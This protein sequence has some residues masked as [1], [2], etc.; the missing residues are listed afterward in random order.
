V[1]AYARGWKERVRSWLISAAS[2][3]AIAAALGGIATWADQ[4]AL[5]AAGPGGVPVH[6]DA[7]RRFLT[8]YSL[9]RL[10]GALEVYRLERG[11]YPPSLAALEEAGLVARRE[12]SSPWLEEYFYRRGPAG[13]YVLLPPLE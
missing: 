11:E 6:D 7:P 3:V 10:R 13:Q 5:A 12:L 2:T 9:E 8:R 4:R 1:G